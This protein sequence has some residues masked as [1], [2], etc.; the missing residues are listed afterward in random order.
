MRACVVLPTYNEAGT[1]AEVVQRVLAASPG[2]QILVVDDDSP[3]GTGGIVDGIAADEPRIRVLHRSHKEGLGPAY[4]AGFADA[5][6]RGYDV[7]I[8]MDSDLSHDPADVARLIDGTS[9]ADLVIGSRYVLGGATTNWSRA[10]ELLSRSANVF[11]RTVL[12]FH[13]RDSTSGFRAYRREVL[14]TLPLERIRSEGYGFQIEM[15]WRAWA[16]GFRIAEIPITF[17]ERREGASKMSRAIVFEAAAKVT[18]WALLLKRAPR[19]PHARSVA[20]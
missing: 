4:L 15:A 3:D 19:A 5:L 7:I 6:S 12:R 10:R 13:L 1:I 9:S 16:L 17:S 2:A 8:E 20:R 14:E 11:A 18:G